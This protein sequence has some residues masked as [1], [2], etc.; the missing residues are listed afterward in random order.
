MGLA[1]GEMTVSF[2]TP[3]DVRT[4]GACFQD[5]ITNGRGAS[6]R[7][8][9]IVVSLMGGQSL[10]FYTPRDDSP[11]AALDEDPPTF[12]VGVAV[13]N[14][15]G[16]HANGTN[17]HMSVWDRGSHRSVTLWAHHSLTG[18]SHASQL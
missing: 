8:G 14:A 6:A 18:G 13:P 12:Q 3:L 2:D 17:V 9:G 16:G 4:C 15:Q 1:M 5:G 10:E 7:V 11:F